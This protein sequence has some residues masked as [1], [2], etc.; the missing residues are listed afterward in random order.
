M[1]AN[2]KKVINHQTLNANVAIVK[3]KVIGVGLDG[4]NHLA[5]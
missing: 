3:T 1:D 4:L 2:V 5:I